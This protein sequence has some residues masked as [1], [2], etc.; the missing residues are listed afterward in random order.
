MGVPQRMPADKPRRTSVFELRFRPVS[1]DTGYITSEAL[2][3]PSPS[4]A[5]PAAVRNQHGRLLRLDSVEERV[6]MKK[7]E[8]YRRMSRGSFPSCV[9]IPG[10]RIVVWTEASIDGWIA[11]VVHPSSADGAPS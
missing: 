6:G 3:H 10:S 2:M 8:I 11:Q 5:D 9:R 1:R 7:S 4:A